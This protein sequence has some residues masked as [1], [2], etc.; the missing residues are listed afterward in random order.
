MGDYFK[1]VEASKELAQGKVLCLKGVTIAIPQGLILGTVLF[2]IFINDSIR[3]RMTFSVD[4]VG[5]HCQN[6]GRSGDQT[7]RPE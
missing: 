6:R 7:K 4:K 5:R 3:S 1:N 2:N